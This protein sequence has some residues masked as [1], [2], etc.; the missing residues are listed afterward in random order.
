MDQFQI[1]YILRDTL[2]CPGVM[3]GFGGAIFLL[4]KKKTMPAI[5]SLIGFLLLGAEPI[6]DL[7]IWQWLSYWDNANYDQLST[8]YACLS[9]LAAFLGAVLIALAFI[10]AFRERKLPPPPPSVDLPPSR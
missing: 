8:T 10:L 3:V 6:L 7:V 2:A 1:I 4:I 9:G 5:L